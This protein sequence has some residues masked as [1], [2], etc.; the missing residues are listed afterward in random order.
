MASSQSLQQLAHLLEHD[1]HESRQAFKQFAL[2][3]NLFVPRYDIMLKYARDLAYERLHRITAEKGFISVFDFQHNPLNIFAIHEVAA[4]LDPSF[5]TKMTVQFNLFGGTLFKLGTDRHREVLKGVDTLKTMGCFALTELGYGNNAVEMETTAKYDNQTGEFIINTPRSQ[6]QK[7][8]ITNGAVHATWAIVFAQLEVNGKQEGIHAFLVRIRNDDLSH[9][10]GVR[11]EDMGLKMG[12]NG[13]DNAKLWF[14]HVRVPRENLLNRYSDVDASGR[15]SSKIEGRRN[16]FLVVADQL[17]AGRLCIASMGIGGAKVALATALS[18]ASTRL[19]V[20]PTGKSDTPILEY[21]LQQRALVPLLVRTIGL[22]FGLNYIKTR[23]LESHM[24]FVNN[25]K[26]DPVDDAEVLRLCCVIKPLTT[27]N[28]ERCSTI[29]RERCGG[30]GYLSVNRLGDA[31][32]ASHAGMTA[33]GDNSVL[34]QKVAKEYL[35]ALQAGHKTLA[36]PSPKGHQWDLTNPEHLLDLL[37]QRESRLFAKLAQAIETKVGKQQQPMFEVWMK[38]ESDTI[39]GASKAY[40]ERT[41]AEAFLNAIHSQS[42]EL[43][44]LLTTLFQIF[45]LHCIE[46]DLG[47][48]VSEEIM[49]PSQGRAVLQNQRDLIKEKIGSKLA[50]DIARHGM[51]IPAELVSKYAPIADDWVGYNMADNE[52][53]L[54]RTPFRTI[55]SKL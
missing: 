34:M 14:N 13:V 48:F 17:L 27:W 49:T 6:G 8:W 30:Q 7:Y 51:G 33:E 19:T 53:E 26:A 50:L 22:N 41:C 42:G 21:Q 40:G 3:D 4:Y 46:L 16:R 31:I 20:G 44:A 38:Q 36:S 45:T 55:G 11:V 25:S 47:Y 54:I 12:M 15:F 23:W 24:R 52:G 5:T 43:K 32:P 18:Y 35:A 2:R 39:Q 9:A 37:K 1:N 28:Q 29:A 10:K